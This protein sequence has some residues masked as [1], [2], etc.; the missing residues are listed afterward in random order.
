MTA[1]ITDCKMS[2]QFTGGAGGVGGVG[3]GP[4]GVGGVGGVGS[5][6]GGTPTVVGVLIHAS[7]H[8]DMIQA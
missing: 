7:V 1:A 4:G 8:V 3:A 2:N 5:G 6:K